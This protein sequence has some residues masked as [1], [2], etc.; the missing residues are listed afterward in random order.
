MGARATGSFFL[1]VFAASAGLSASGFA[2]AP[3]IPVLKANPPQGVES[4]LF[5]AGFLSVDVGNDPQAVVA[6]DWNADGHL[7]LAVANAGSRTISIL[8]GNGT[9]RFHPPTDI[10]AGPRSR[11]LIAGDV[12]GDAK[13]DLVVA[14]SSSNS[15][16]TL[17][18]DGAGGF[19]P[20][21]PIAT[22]A[23]PCAAA[24]GDLN[25]DL[26]LDLVLANEDADS[27]SVHFG[28]G[29]GSFLAR[30]TRATGESPRALAITDLNMD[31]M[32]DLVVANSGSASLSSYLGDGAGN[33]GA[34]IDASTVA[35]PVAFA[36]ADITQDGL[37]DAVVLGFESGEVDRLVGDGAG[38]F[39]STYC[40]HLFVYQPAAVVA[41][42][43]DHDGITDFAVAE[44]G[45]SVL[46][47]FYGL[48][49]S[50][51]EDPVQIGSGNNPH[52][53][54]VGDFDANGW[55]DLV[56]ANGGYFSPSSGTSVAVHL[57]TGDRLFGET[58]L[59]SGPNPVRGTSSV[60]L[61]DLNGD[62]KID[63]ALANRIGSSVGIFPGNGDETF[64]ARLDWYVG[65]GS[66]DLAAADLN[67]DGRVDLVVTKEFAKTVW[68]VL[69]DGV[70]REFPIPGIPLSIATCR[71]P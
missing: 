37:L 61:E 50:S 46:S 69:G 52:A 55:S 11:S 18:G 54:A 12:N 8:L 3:A 29:D 44:Q 4:P 60:L 33:F 19:T 26:R 25:G 13:L 63:V 14:D 16:T 34:K 53:L 6:G 47:I 31:S 58:R 71:G 43:L 38:T 67:R 48:T 65:G 51:F 57:G 7:D 42:D 17:L 41:E 36:L 28:M 2:A 62:G 30:S 24:L 49:I 21:P 23:G 1:A 10:A 15:A 9:G 22:A 66:S 39:V 20:L 68:V 70:V 27:V 56:A 40:C 32:L 64:G 45:N 59:E 5:Q 35:S